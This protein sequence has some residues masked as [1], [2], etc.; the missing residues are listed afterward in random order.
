MLRLRLSLLTSLM[1]LSRII[2]CN[3]FLPPPNVVTH[4]STSPPPARTTPALADSKSQAAQDLLDRA[5]QLRGEVAALEGKTLAEVEQESREKKEREKQAEQNKARLTQQQ[6]GQQNAA[7][8]RSLQV[9]ITRDDM[10]WQASQAVERAYRDGHLKRQTVRFALL[11]SEEQ[12]IRDAADNL[13]P[14]GAQQMARQAGKPTTRELLSRLRRESSL[15]EQ[16][17]WDFDGSALLT[18]EAKA[19]PTEDVQALVFPNTDVKYIRDIEAIDEAM[20]D[21][22][23]LLVNP[24]WRNVESWGFNLLAPGAKKKAQEVIFEN[25][26]EETYVCMRFSVRGEDCVA[27]K[28]YPYDWQIF[29]YYE[30]PFGGWETT[31]R[32]GECRNE[33]KSEFVTELLNSRPEFK[34]SKTMRQMKR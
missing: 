30:D 26:Y 12:P 22:L 7:R 5:A 21:R 19:G 33:P 18:A 14:G 6:P 20:G 11:E 25:G 9:P 3:A 2:G 17:V 29:A 31:I 13:W 1:A 24:F 15:K 27:I 16:D 4:T 23:F 34:E 8:G 32:L 28:A 10:V